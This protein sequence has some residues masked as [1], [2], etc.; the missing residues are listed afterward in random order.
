MRASSDKSAYWRLVKAS[1]NVRDRPTMNGNEDSL[2]GC[3]WQ[4]SEGNVSREEQ[5]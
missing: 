5:S 4:R 3:Y 2:H 1:I